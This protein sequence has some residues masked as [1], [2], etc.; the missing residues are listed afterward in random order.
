MV[1]LDFSMPGMDGKAA[2]EEL[3]KINKNVRV[4]LCSGYSE[5]EMMSGFGAIRPLGFMKK[6]Y[7]PSDL[8]ERVSSMLL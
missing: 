7:K 5:E 8:L 1:V 6:P 4:L 2:F 3:T